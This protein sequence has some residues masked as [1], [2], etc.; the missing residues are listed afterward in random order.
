MLVLIGVLLLFFG[1][2]IY[3]G[4]ALGVL[5]LIVGFAFSDRPFWNFIGQM[6]WGPSSSFVLVA[7]PLF[8]L[9]GE[10]TAA[11]RPV[12]APLPRAQRLAATACRAG[13]CTPTSC[14]AACS[15]RSP[16]RASRPRRRWARSRC[17][18]FRDTSYDPRMVLG[19]LAA[20]GA[21]GNL[22]PP[23]ITFIIYGLI[24]ETSVGALYLAAVGP[25]HPGGAAVHR[26]DPRCTACATA[27]WRR[28][29]PAPLR[30]EAASLVD[31]VPTALLIVLVLG[32]IYAGLATPTES[33]ALGVVGAWCFA[34]DRRQASLAML[35]ESANATA[36]TTAMIGADPVRRLSPQLHPDAAAHAA[37]A[38]RRPWRAAA[39]AAGRSC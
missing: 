22:I 5:G 33:A 23:G 6:I 28:R 15:P 20:G 27:A 34:A 38:G 19:S 7:V 9:M 37:D 11:R 35:H 25:E 18:Y 10:I 13:C 4:A 8:L 21:L 12:G 2:G 26:R 30:G 3:V 17:P 29:A 32:T 36:R 24:T 14:R 31:L 1:S 16:A 39:A